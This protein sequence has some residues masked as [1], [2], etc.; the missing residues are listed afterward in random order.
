MSTPSNA[1]EDVNNIS[2]SNKSEPEI[3]VKGSKS[4]KIYAVTNGRQTGLFTSWDLCQLSVNK[5]SGAKYSSF[6]NVKLAQKF[7]SDNGYDP[8][9]V[10]IFT[11]FEES[12]ILSELKEI[13]E[14]T[15]CEKTNMVVENIETFSIPQAMINEKISNTTIENHRTD[16]QAPITTYIMPDQISD[17][18]IADTDS[19]PDTDIPD[20]LLNPEPETPTEIEPKSTVPVPVSEIIKQQSFSDM[21]NQCDENKLQDPAIDLPIKFTEILTSINRHL[22]F[23]E[24]IHKLEDKLINK[25]TN[26]EKVNTDLRIQIVQKDLDHA[27]DMI[28]RLKRE[29][30]KS[31]SKDQT[32]DKI[33]EKYA[34]LEIAMEQQK[35]SYQL[36]I[37]KLDMKYKML[38]LKLESLETNKEQ[39]SA[40]IKNLQSDVDL[41]KARHDVKSDLLE[42]YESQN[43]D[44][45]NKISSLQDE[46]FAL[47]LQGQTSS[48]DEEFFKP[49]VTSKPHRDQSPKSIAIEN[50]FA[51][52]ENIEI[53]MEKP[54]P[55]PNTQ[56]LNS[57]KDPDLQLS[58]EAMKPTQTGKNA[59]ETSTSTDEPVDVLFI[60]N[61]HVSKIDTNKLY[62]NKNC[63]IHCLD[64]G[65]KD[66]V[67]AEN[68]IK[69]S[70]VSD[71]KIIVFQV[72]SNN[73]ES[74]SA[75]LCTNEIKTLVNLTENKY[76]NSKICI[77]EAL[78]R[79]LQT[80]RLTNTYLENMKTFNRN[81][82]KIRN[83][84]VVKHRNIDLRQRN[85]WSDNIHLS[86]VG[87][88]RFIRNFKFLL[89]PLLNMKPYEEYWRSTNDEKS[90]RYDERTNY[91][92]TA[93][94][95]PQ[96][97]N[98]NNS[99][100]DFTHKHSN[101]RSMDTS[102]SPFSNNHPKS[103]EY[104]SDD[105]CDLPT[106][107]RS[108]QHWKHYGD[109]PS[110]SFP[111]KFLDDIDALVKRYRHS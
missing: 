106:Q 99:R 22:D 13:S 110:Q 68:Y 44:L 98:M 33:S 31:E 107:S 55:T 39:S 73:L 56:K 1:Q 96:R 51:G 20:C 23:S 45:S 111:T 29:L 38:C 43:S 84:H 105:Q 89:N 11:S 46:I 83:I 86:E 6:K 58:Y 9:D 30:S 10:K 19:L 63:V 53:P 12:P 97:N 103:Y 100:D 76:P 88:A 57:N 8:S 92:Q 82:T 18:L 41:W 36:E 7:M 102:P 101:Y 52:L 81:I 27:N 47:K 3:Q 21:I 80:V 61:S 48:N 25:L 94:Y 50:R 93:P 15:D 72:A 66:I 108:A 49:K 95:N 69:Q 65:Q 24:E 2:S 109:N 42:K 4:S 32:A 91:H 37:N 16:T 17:K 67:G 79:E 74:L 77:G 104:Y 34:L 14:H 85:L 90:L 5:Y 60:G 62:K 35:S 78:P 70:K 64:A 54:M 59:P 71:P 40:I 28:T 87:M 26:S 75:E